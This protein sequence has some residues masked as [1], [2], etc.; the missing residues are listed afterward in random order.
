MKHLVACSVLCMAVSFLQGCM[1]RAEA[2]KE[3]EAGI[4]ACF[5]QMDE[6]PALAQVNSKYARREPTPAQLADNSV[7]TESEA[8]QL[9]TRV[10]RTKPC[11][12]LRL[13]A[14][15]DTEPLLEPAYAILYYQADQ[16]FSYLQQQAV[17]YGTANK[18]SGQALQMFRSRENKY[19]SGSE[20]ERVSLAAEL[21]DEL[22]R[23]H[24]EPP[25]TPDRR[26]SW[27][28]LNIVCR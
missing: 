5:K 14:V 13:A 27:Q 2:W 25:P 11:R 17:T 12:A 1:T 15:R 6:D 3:S 4:A 28:D 19:F 16:V 18:L 26:C 9:R 21:T 23:A 24:S 22:Q 10:E 8:E 20:A 7:P